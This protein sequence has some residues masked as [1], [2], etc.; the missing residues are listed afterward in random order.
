[1]TSAHTGEPAPKVRKS[2]AKKIAPPEPLLEPEPAPTPAP[3]CEG[4]AEQ[5]A[6]LAINLPPSVLARV[7]KQLAS[8]GLDVS[9][10][11]LNEVA[12]KSISDQLEHATK[13]Y[14][15]KRER[16]RLASAKKRAELKEAEKVAIIE[17]KEI[18]VS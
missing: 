13:L 12:A 5:F 16:A 3:K 17:P 9:S 2:R 10:E 8:K 15:Q 18:A 7:S 1:M 14:Q 11:D 4:F 6:G